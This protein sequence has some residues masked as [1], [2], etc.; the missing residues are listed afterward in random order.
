MILVFYLVAI[1]PLIQAEISLGTGSS[2]WED[3]KNEF[4]KMVE[5]TEHLK[6]DFDDLFTQKELD[7]MEVDMIAFTWYTAHNAD[8]D[9]GLDGLELLKALMHTRNHDHN[10][11][12]VDDGGYHAT[13]E[14]L[15][16]DQTQGFVDSLLAN[17]D[18]NENGLLE[19]GEFMK[20]YSESGDSFKTP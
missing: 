11:G 7:E 19:Y 2:R 12:N 1:L 17:Y 15:V 20:A 13:Q 10:D 4:N 6:E 18:T 9:D 14:A 5:D 16:W 8:E 3:S